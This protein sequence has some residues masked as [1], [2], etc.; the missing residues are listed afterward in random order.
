MNIAK[1][2]LAE[3]SK[4]LDV[5]KILERKVVKIPSNKIVVSGRPGVSLKSDASLRLS[6]EIEGSLI[7]PTLHLD[8]SKMLPEMFEIDSVGVRQ[9]NSSLKFYDDIIS[10]T[11]TDMGFEPDVPTDVNEY[12]TFL[13]KL[14]W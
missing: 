8:R 9:V 12:Q 4:S 6:V 11:P 7:L 1:R 2:T 13:Q 3:P 14:L 5:F 10:L